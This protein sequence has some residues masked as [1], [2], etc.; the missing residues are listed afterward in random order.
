M[1]EFKN[2]K[3]NQPQGTLIIDDVKLI[4]KSSFLDY[5]SGGTQLNLVLAIDFTASNQNPHHPS[6]LHYRDP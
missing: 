3:E 6:S 5:I 4:K 1:R 2:L